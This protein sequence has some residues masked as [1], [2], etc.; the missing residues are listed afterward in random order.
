MQ[1]DYL[2]DE[3]LID[4]L[5]KMDMVFYKEAGVVSDLLSGAQSMVSNFVQNHID[6]SST[7]AF[8]KSILNLLAPG[9]FFK[10][11]PV[12]GIIYTAGSQFG[13]DASTILSNIISVIKP[14]IMGGEQIDPGEINR[15]AGGDIVQ[16]MK[17]L[18]NIE[19]QGALIKTAQRYN[20]PLGGSFF[21]QKGAP[22]L[23]NLFGFM[24][25]K[26]SGGAKSLAAGFIVWFIKT[27]L[28]S[29]GLLAGAGAIKHFVAPDKEETQEPQEDNFNSFKNETEKGT[30]TKLP[31]VYDV[32]YLPL[33]NSSPE[34][35]IL[36]WITG[37]N[38]DLSGYEDIIK[39]VPGYQLAVNLLKSKHQAGKD[40]V[41]VPKGLDEKS[42]VNSIVPE[43]RAEMNKE[44]TP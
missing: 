5:A 34:K 44:I 13:F 43:V 15:A 37:F 39:K 42:I 28:L 25:N 7:G 3:I 24:N 36:E 16:A 22:L 30:E 17:E 26:K 32:K 8:L 4:K 20:K 14:K 27:V 6:S 38:P 29:A 11:H 2:A 35:T 1:I 41:E 21:G 33:I 31:K 10:A 9:L 18:H 12:L 19:K 40:Y 23:H